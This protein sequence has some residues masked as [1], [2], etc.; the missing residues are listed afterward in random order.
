MAVSI[1]Q[2]SDIPVG[3][4]EI[5]VVNNLGHLLELGQPVMDFDLP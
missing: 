4:A 3:G 1:T 2:W 5:S